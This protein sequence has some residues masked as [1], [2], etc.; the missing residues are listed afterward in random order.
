MKDKLD[1]ANESF[2]EIS[3]SLTKVEK[4]V[5]TMTYMES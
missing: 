2:P 4:D 1:D 5:M 3:G